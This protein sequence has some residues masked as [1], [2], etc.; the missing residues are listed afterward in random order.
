ME[1]VVPKEKL[2][3]FLAVNRFIKT[4]VF[5]LIAASS[6]HAQEQEVNLELE[7]PKKSYDLIF[8]LDRGFINSISDK[9]RY[10]GEYLSEDLQTGEREWNWENRNSDQDYWLDFYKGR[11]WKLDVMLSTIKN[12]NIGLTYSFTYL[13]RNDGLNAQELSALRNGLPDYVTDDFAILFFTL[14][15]I[16]DYNFP[17]AKNLY[18]N[19]S[20]SVGAY[21]SQRGLEGA[22]RELTW[23]GRLA[24]EYRLGGRLCVR[25]HAGYQNMSYRENETSILYTDRE[26]S[27]KIDW[28]AFQTGFGFAYHFILRP[29]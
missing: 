1:L 12:L 6:V 15:G 27:V 10:E 24:L 3:K 17:I 14:G 19:P 2:L 26:R 18:V 9:Y 16:V 25:A 29:D 28:N 21:Q 5:F 20:L 8:R 11:T 7:T 23:D 13:R 4:L 22:G